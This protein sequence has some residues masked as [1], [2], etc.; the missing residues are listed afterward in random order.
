MHPPPIIFVGS[1]KLNYNRRVIRW[2]FPGAWFDINPCNLVWGDQRLGNPDVIDAQ[3]HVSPKRSGPIIPPGE[4]ASLFVMKAEGISE[5][6][7]LY[8]V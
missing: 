8:L 4:L 5:S 2:T 7:T 6:P 3:S 1:V